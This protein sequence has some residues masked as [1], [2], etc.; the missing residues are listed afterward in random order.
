VGMELDEDGMGEGAAE[1]MLQGFDGL[2]ELVEQLQ[3][4]AK[5]LVN[6]YQ[7]VSTFIKS[8]DIPWPSAF[9]VIMSKV[10]IINLNLVQLPA[11]ACLNPSPSYYKQFNGF[12]LGLVGAMLF[13]GAMFL[14]G[15]YVLAPLTLRGLPAEEMDRRVGKFQSTILGRA[16]L[17]LYLVYPG[18][19]VSVFGIFSCTATSYASFLD[20]DMTITC[21]DSTHWRY[22]AAGVVWVFVI[23]VGVPYFFIRLLRHF[24]VP[25]MAQ[26]RADNAWL[27]EAAQLA[28][29][30]G[31]AQNG[32]TMST[33]NVDNIS[34]AH[35]EASCVGAAKLCAEAAFSGCLATAK[36]ASAASSRRA[37][38]LTALLVWC[39]TSGKLALPVLEWEEM[40]VEEAAKND[41]EL[42]EEAIEEQHAA[43]A[44]H[45]PVAQRGWPSWMSPRPSS[46]PAAIACSDLPHL[47]RIA[48]REIGFLFAAYHTQTWYWEVR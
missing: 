48:L 38:V 16:L 44:A 40:D 7:I 41:H 8:L 22:V 18:V 26:L 33:L 12:T 35:L 15:K 39:R 30:M 3:R 11:A 45:P 2:E 17:I 27:Q 23:P 46:Q 10:N 36:Q 31:L 29:T 19:S 47:Q 13:M 24:M 34:D 43:L 32:I 14:F 9:T 4:V 5:I 28:W 6:F 37:T 1:V 21:W 42:Y 25:Q 20:A